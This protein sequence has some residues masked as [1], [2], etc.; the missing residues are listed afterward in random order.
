MRGDFQ[1]HYAAI[2]ENLRQNP[3]IAGV[4]AGR[5][6]VS[7]FNSAFNVRVGGREMPPEIRMSRAPVDIDY[8]MTMG[9]KIKEGRGF[10]PDRQGPDN[11]FILNEKAVEVLG[12]ANPL[13]TEILFSGYGRDLDVMEF[14][15]TIAGVVEDFH[16]GPLHNPIGPVI[17]YYSP[18]ELYD[19]CVRVRPDKTT[20]AIA[21]VQSEWNEY[22]AAYPF[23]YH[24][25]DETIDG[26]YASERQLEEIFRLFTLLAVLISCLGLYGLVSFMADRRTKEIGI[27]K[28]LG[29][30]VAGIVKLITR[31]FILLVVVAG[32]IA[33]PLVGLAMNRWLQTFAYRI[34]L[35]WSIFMAAGVLMITVTLLT[36]GFHAVESALANPVESLRHE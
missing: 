15:G 5:P 11:T 28:V 36:V 23:D 31:E 19:I 10:S 9:M 17:M 7:R 21:A 33:G 4:T 32:A 3:A 24:F 1:K 18:D 6:P 34:D 13:D 8:L 14:S 27:R 26:F 2:K 35:D 29:A 22:A 30:S 20:E 25:V 12:L 16:Y